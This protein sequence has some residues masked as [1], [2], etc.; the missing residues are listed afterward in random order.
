MSPPVGNARQQGDR[1]L[2]ATADTV[3]VWRTRRLQK[4]SIKE[5]TRGPVMM[6]GGD[7]SSMNGCS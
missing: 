3:R 5:I 4:V 6:S 2:P 7:G 1:T